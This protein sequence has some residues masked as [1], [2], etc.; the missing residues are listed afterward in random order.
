MNFKSFIFLLGVISF[1]SCK[2]SQTQPGVTPP[3]VADNT[4]FQP[5][6]TLT[7]SKKA[8]IG[9]PRIQLNPDT[10]Y[11]DANKGIP[12]FKTLPAGFD[13]AI[14]SFYLPMGYL[15]VFAENSD[16]TGASACYVASQSAI[17]ANLP[18]RL[19]NRVSFIRYI[20]VANNSKK[21][22]AS[23]D[24]NV[25][26]LF[27]TSWYYGWSLN[28]PSFGSQQYVP[29]TWG[30]GSATIENVA[31]FFD[32]KDIDHLLSFNE[33]DNAT[34]SN[35]PNIDTAIARYK[36]MMQSG[37]RLGAPATTQDQV[38]GAGKW[39]TNF[40]AAAQAQ[41]IRIDFIP[42]HWYDWGNQTNNQATD[43]LTAQAVFNRF[44]TYVE[45]V[46]T[47]YPAQKIWITE[48]NANPGRTSL[49]VHKYFM[50]LSAEWMNGLTYLERYAYFFPASVPAVDANGIMTEA[51]R[52][53]NDLV[54]PVSFPANIE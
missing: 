39:Q 14:V 21:G 3:V 40:I 35:I 29:M 11:S 34:Q 44:K 24:S 41:N 10:A 5:G 48:Y 8:D 43:S 30:K 26:K 22:I 38:F 17:K 23:T 4:P 20:P 15:V 32:R 31:Y 52:Y 51:G 37:L 46:H 42:L 12:K 50:K 2:K 47:E 27:T 53:W 25:V 49:V 9:T 1:F 33:P 45:R 7:I 54:S 18:D 13:D 28:R 36:V 6:A 19:K 16:G